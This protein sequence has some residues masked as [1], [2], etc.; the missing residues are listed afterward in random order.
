[1]KLSSLIL[2]VLLFIPIQMA[3]AQT[4]PTMPTMAEVQR[5]L[6]SDDHKDRAWGAYWASQGVLR[7]FEPQLRRNLEAHYDLSGWKNDIVTDTTLD[8]FI[9]FGSDSLS[10]DFLRSLYSRRKAQTLILLSE[11]N[12]QQS[13]V[14][15]WMLQLLKDEADQGAG[16]EWFAAADLL[17]RDRAAGLVK[18]ILTDLRIEPVITVCDTALRCTQT[19]G[20]MGRVGDSIIRIDSGYPGWPRYGISRQFPGFAGHTV[21]IQGPTPATTMTYNRYFDPEA[22]KTTFF[23]GSES[24]YPT[25]PTSAERMQYI[26]AASGLQVPISGNERLEVMWTDR[27]AYSTA[28]D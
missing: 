9:R 7:Q 26:A 15:K 20:G 10:V 8:A 6:E 17:L 22:G 3:G 19:F 18:S 5:L 25:H 23:R 21:F 27:A 11:P 4:M 16:L 2:M 24:G 13:E 1:M 28:V 14:H 12:R